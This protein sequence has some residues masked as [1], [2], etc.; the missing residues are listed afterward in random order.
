M[1]YRV[2]QYRVWTDLQWLELTRHPTAF[3]LSTC[4][5]TRDFLKLLLS[6]QN[7]P[8]QREISA[9]RFLSYMKK[10]IV[11]RF[12]CPI[13]KNNNNDNDKLLRGQ[14]QRIYKKDLP[15]VKVED[16][17]FTITITKGG[18]VS[19]LQM[20]KQTNK[21]IY[22]LFQ[23]SQARIQKSKSK[24]LQF[25]WDTHIQYGSTSSNLFNSDMDIYIFYMK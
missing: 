8:G 1:G 9:E 13:H 23:R 15:S 19:S 24:S 11:G 16:R 25:F 5:N 20:E 10:D 2:Y 21:H 6:F 18:L 22:C 12:C 14:H 3:R 17:I 4:E 7:L